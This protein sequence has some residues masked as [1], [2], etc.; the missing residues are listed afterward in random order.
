MSEPLATF[1][2]AGGSDPHSHE[3]VTVDGSGRVRALV[4]TAWPDGA[5]AD[6]AGV[7]EWTLDA[8]ELAALGAELEAV[9][10]P[11]E[12]RPSGDAGGFSLAVAGRRLRWGPFDELSAKLAAVARRFGG[13]R[14]EAREHP[15]AAVRLTL[16]PPLGFRFEALGSDPVG[17]TVRGVSARVVPAGEGTGPPPL[18]WAR[19]AAPLR[20]PVPEARTLDPG[21]SLLV[22]ADAPPSG[23]RVDGF[24]EVELAVPGRDGGL[25]A[26]VAAGPLLT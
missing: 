25:L 17:L 7:F 12:S 22:G 5:P 6:R 20:V 24:A 13:L 9:E 16:E 2:A 4:A 21:D 19:E 15:R 1:A 8:G 10:A 11:G 18:L 3:V 14:A 23:S 26:V